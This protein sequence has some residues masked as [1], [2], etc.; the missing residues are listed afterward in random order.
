MNTSIS[1]LRLA[2]V[3]ALLLASLGSRNACAT[4]YTWTG[5]S[6][7]V[8]GVAG[9]W[10]SSGGSSFPSAN[11]DTSTFGATVTTNQPDVTSSYLELGLTFLSPTGG[12]TINSGAASSSFLKVYGSGI[13][14]LANVGGTDTINVNL[15][16]QT[17]DNWS[18]GTGGK[19]VL[20]GGIGGT[21][22][23]TFGTLTT[24]EGEIDLNGGD[25]TGTGNVR[26]GT[27]T[28]ATHFALQAGSIVVGNN[29]AFGSIGSTSQT[30][31]FNSGGDAVLSSS[32][33]NLTLGNN[34]SL[35]GTSTFAGSNNMTLTGVVSSSGTGTLVYKGSG[36]LT[37]AGANTYTGLT[38]VQS[39]SLLVSGSL[40]ATDH[41]TVNGGA[42]FGIG[43][44]AGAGSTATQ[45]TGAY[46]TGTSGG[47]QGKL[48]LDLTA[49]GNDELTTGAFTLN[50]S[51]DLI[52]TDTTLSGGISSLTGPYTLITW[53][54]GGF[55]S[56]ATQLNLTGSSS[57]ITMS[58]LSLSGN[59]L[60]FTASSVPEPSTYMLLGMGV[61]ALLWRRAGRRAS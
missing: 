57:D 37:L 56:L 48:A 9:N 7:A 30:V 6:S 18:T 41:V 14:D 49:T 55:T 54:S 53:T 27:P 35:Q 19:L 1:S 4:D 32:I 46:I 60:I 11:T 22:T 3:G 25:L 13:N 16:A 39:G 44:A 20:N 33:S 10:S 36:S 28:G 8:W 5:S 61:L 15:T 50:S 43:M 2:A 31:I 12:W 52:L 38:T 40:A 47:S 42:L 51:L 23:V 21:G 24:G 58:E 34:F 59:S 45:A 26:G 29:A 17:G